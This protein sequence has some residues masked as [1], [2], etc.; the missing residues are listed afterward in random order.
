[1][2]STQLSA[3]RLAATGCLDAGRRQPIDEQA[4]HGNTAT[5]SGTTSTT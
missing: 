5:L 2:R 3:H 1:M 4:R